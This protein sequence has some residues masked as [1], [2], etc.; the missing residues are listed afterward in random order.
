[1][2][3]NTM[4]LNIVEK[5]FLKVLKPQLADAIRSG[6]PNRAASFAKELARL[7]RKRHQ[8]RKSVK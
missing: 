8:Q 3:G 6:E 1:M 7:Q 5:E 4:A 2:K